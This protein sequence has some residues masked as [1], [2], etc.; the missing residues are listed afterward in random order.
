MISR[1]KTEEENQPKKKIE[2]MKTESQKGAA[3]AKNRDEAF[4]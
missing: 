2:K 3:R 4:A 1:Q